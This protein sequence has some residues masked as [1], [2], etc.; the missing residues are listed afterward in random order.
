MSKIDVPQADEQQRLLANLITEMNRD[1][2]PLPRF[3]YLPR[4]EKAAL[5]ETG[6][7]H[8]RGRHPGLLRPA[9]GIEPGRLLGGRLGV[10]ARDLV[11]VSRHG[12]DRR[13]GRRVRGRRLRGRA[14][15]GHRLRCNDFTPESLEDDLT[16]QLVALRGRVAE[17]QEAGHQ[18]HPLHRLER[19]GHRAEAREGARDPLRHEL[20]LQRPSRLAHQARP[21]HRLRLP[22]ALRRPRRLADRR[23]PGDD[24][25]HGRVRDADGAAGGHPARQRAR[26]EGAGTAWSPSSTTP[27]TAITPTPTT[28]SPPPRTAGSRWCPRPRCSTGS[29]AATPPPSR[30]WHTAA[31]S[32]PSRSSRTRRPAG[33]RR[34]CRP[35]RPPDRCPA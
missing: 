23:L 8:A 26:P 29:T 21:A 3:W 5:V 13:P 28:S 10:R 7:D 22:A 19:L 20:L 17:R 6:D 18:P 1:K 34:C 24:A 32:S 14:S 27:T 2:A 25:G 4:G 35:S 16:T 12:D 33:S 31:G 9:E 30:T 11:P 15:P